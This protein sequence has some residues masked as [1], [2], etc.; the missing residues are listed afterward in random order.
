M[1]THSSHRTW[2]LIKLFRFYNYKAN[3]EASTATTKTMDCSRSISLTSRPHPSVGDVEDMRATQ[4]RYIPLHNKKMTSHFSRPNWFLRKTIKF[5][6]T[7][8]P[9][10]ARAIKLVSILY[11]N[12]TASQ[13]RLQSRCPV[14]LCQN[15]KYTDIIYNNNNIMENRQNWWRHNI[16]LI[17]R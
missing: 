8:C 12:R 2:H 14:F 5:L 4:Q 3:M 6:Q 13:K 15:Y 9:C 11:Q 7:P 16:Q 17:L 1:L 10:L